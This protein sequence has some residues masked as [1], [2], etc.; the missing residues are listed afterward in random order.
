AAGR[1]KW[2]SSLVN[3]G[4]IRFLEKQRGDETS[5]ERRRRDG[6]PDL[7][8]AIFIDESDL[9]PSSRNFYGL[10]RVVGAPEPRRHTSHVTFPR[11]IENLRDHEQGRFRTLDLDD[12]MMREELLGKNF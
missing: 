10:K 4:W 7:K 1:T 5:E 6:C 2:N 12:N 8:P 3:L 11:M 9:L